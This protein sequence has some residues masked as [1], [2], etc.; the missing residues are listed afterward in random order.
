MFMTGSFRLLFGAAGLLA[1]AGCQTDV[2]V[3]RDV[4]YLDGYRPVAEPGRAPFD[5]VSFW[6]GDG[7]GGKASVKISLSEQRAFFYR[8]G[9]LV[10]LSAISTGRE[11]FNSPKGNFQ[12]LDKDAA[13]VSSLYGDYV[14]AQGQVVQKDVDRKKDPIPAGCK[15]DGAKMP[16]FMRFAGGVGM[17][18]GFLPGYAA[19]HG[20]IRMPEFMAQKFFENVSKGTPVRVED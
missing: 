2:R 8:D 13:H 1:L 6:E 7:V 17:H 10:G 12:I 9:R 5:N 15:F 18:Q 14:D 19:S 11:G 4:S 20:C 3:R 16:Y